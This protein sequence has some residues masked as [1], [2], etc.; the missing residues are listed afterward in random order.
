MNRN[1]IVGV[2]ALL[3]AVI[4]IA[5][6]YLP[7]ESSAPSETVSNEVESAISS[8]VIE[9]GKKLRNVSLLMPEAD[10]QQKMEAEYG[11]YV[12]PE[13]LLRWQEAP[14]EALGRSVSSPWPER[15]EVVSITRGGNAY[16]V[17]GNV[18]EV[19]S[20]DAPSEPAAVYP[21]TL[22]M[23]NRDGKWLIAEVQ[24]G[25]YSKLPGR[26][27]VLGQWEC[28]PHTNQV[29][30]Q[31]LECAFGIKSDDGKH[32]GVDLA[33]LEIA[34]VDYPTGTRIRVEGVLTRKEALSSNVWQKYP[35]EGIIGVTGIDEI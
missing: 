18:I 9:F 32:Y 31:T 2:I 6:L 13:L 1:V 5:I 8:N 24:K 25:A 3:A 28:L 33:L 21:V 29:G 22:T 11:A 4:A 34:P 15:I 23:E 30:P 27:T 26:I 14:G 7:R 16:I 12:T 10:L 19:T 35:I 20:A 17:E